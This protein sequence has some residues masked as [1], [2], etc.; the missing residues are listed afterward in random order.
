MMQIKSTLF[1]KSSPSYRDCPNDDMPLYAFIGRSNVG[2]SSLINMLTDTKGLAKTSGTPGKTLLINH[3]LINESFYFVDL[4]GYGFAKISKTAKKGLR[5]MVFSY[6][7]Y[8]ENLQ[9]IFVLIDSRLE[10][11]DID[12]NFVNW[13]GEKQ[14]P[15]CLVF[16]KSDKLKKNELAS[17]ISAYKKHL[18]KYWENLPKIIITSAELKTG[19]EE[20]LSFVEEINKSFAG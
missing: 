18:S 17:N 5:E 6:L 10:P 11:Q 2:K 8:T 16:T 13:I 7:E 12:I 15:L 1:I 9:T 3:F 19:K 14:L 4:P 20:I